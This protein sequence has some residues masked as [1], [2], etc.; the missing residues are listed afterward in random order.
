MWG[1]FV[2][3]M[4]VT[5]NENQKRYNSVSHLTAS[6]NAESKKSWVSN[7]GFASFLM[8]ICLNLHVRLLNI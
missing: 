8:M 7:P 5:A 6:S 2:A 4:I 3:P 1:T